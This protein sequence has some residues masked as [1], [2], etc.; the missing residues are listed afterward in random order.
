MDGYRM[1]SM[2]IMMMTMILLMMMMMHRDDYDGDDVE[3]D[4]SQL[5]N[6]FV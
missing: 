5:Q 3:S 2:V 1:M 6:K 4:S